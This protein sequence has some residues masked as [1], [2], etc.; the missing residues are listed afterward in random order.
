[1]RRIPTGVVGAGA[2]DAAAEDAAGAGAAAGGGAGGAVGVGDALLELVLPLH[3]RMPRQT[4][5]PIHSIA[6]T[7]RVTNHTA[8]N[9]RMPSWR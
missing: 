1:M 5:F 9:A 4:R 7:C 3:E 8:T 6:M 2:E